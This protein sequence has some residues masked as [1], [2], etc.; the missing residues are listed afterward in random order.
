[1]AMNER[2]SV[3]WTVD[4]LLRPVVIAAMLACLTS[5]LVYALQGLNLGYNGGHFVA[6]AF[7]ASL[8]GILSERVLQRRRITSWA[9]LGSRLAEAVLL[10]LLL[11]QL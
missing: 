3:N 1:M 8:E 5:P 2:T 6:F 7:L 9:Y 4:N 10:L 11:K